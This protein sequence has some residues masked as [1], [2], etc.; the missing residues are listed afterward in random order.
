MQRPVLRLGEPP[1]H[2]QARRI[3]GAL[4]GWFG[5]GEFT[6]VEAS[7]CLIEELNLDHRTAIAALQKLADMDAVH[8][9][10]AL[11]PGGLL[12]PLRDPNKGE[13]G[14]KRQVSDI[15]A[16]LTEIPYEEL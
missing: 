10:R 11:I 1:T 2:P 9:T 14:H 15:L 4:F 7:M 13:N 16:D 8:M 6:A 5:P 3:W 12:K